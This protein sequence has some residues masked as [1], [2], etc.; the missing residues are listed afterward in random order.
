[1]QLVPV[2]L[3]HIDTCLKKISKLYER[4]NVSCFLKL[5]TILLPFSGDEYET[6]EMPKIEK[7]KIKI[8]VFVMFIYNCNFS[9]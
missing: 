8:F 4:S 6:N 5:K 1:M 3:Q 7:S 9:F 2:N